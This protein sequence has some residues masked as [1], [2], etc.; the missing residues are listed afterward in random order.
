MATLCETMTGTHE[1]LAAVFVPNL[2]KTLL[3]V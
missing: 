1:R 3:S 2:V